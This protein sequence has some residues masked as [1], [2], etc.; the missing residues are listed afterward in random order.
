MI[1]HLLNK[2]IDS[3]RYDYEESIKSGERK[4]REASVKAP[5]I[6]IKPREQVFPSS[7]KAFLSNPKNKDN[8]N[9]FM[10]EEMVV[11]F[12]G[13]LMEGQCLVLAG[14]FEGTKL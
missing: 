10:F 11:A 6:K 12:Q 9:S 3:D 14:G 7:L 8:F 13:I 1:N 5:E 2:N 4:R